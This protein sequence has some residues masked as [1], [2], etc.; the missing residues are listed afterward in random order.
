[1]TVLK[2]APKFAE[3][4]DQYLDYYKN[5]VDGKR[6]STL[7]TEG[8]AIARLKEHMGHLRL[9]QIKR[10]HVD[11]FVLK[12]QRELK[13]AR[14]VNLEVTVLR[15]VLNKAIDDKWINE[16]PTANL[17]PLKS[18]RRKRPLASAAEIDRLCAVG[19]RPVFFAGRLAEE[20]E[21]GHPLQSARQFSDYIRL[22]CY[23]GARL[24]EAL[25]L[26]WADIDW[27]NRQLTIGADGGAKNR[28]WRVVDLNANLE[29]HLKEMLV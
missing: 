11:S 15:N 3:F 27:Q 5:V 13:A 16:L 2:Q 14:T 20:T 7:E 4:A 22:L 8:H 25:Q 21:T 19:F 29:A 18:V 12:R 24:S 10:I 28:L 23:S 6:A 1:M 26:R 9:N 17:R